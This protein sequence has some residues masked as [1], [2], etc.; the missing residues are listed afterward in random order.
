MTLSAEVII[1]F[2]RVYRANFK[3]YCV[4]HNEFCVISHIL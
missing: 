2:V 1:V 4:K 3:S